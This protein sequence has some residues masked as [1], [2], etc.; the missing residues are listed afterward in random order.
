VKPISIPPSAFQMRQVD[1][2]K[3]VEAWTQEQMAQLSAQ[4]MK[5]IREL[6]ELAENRLQETFT[7]SAGM[8]AQLRQNTVLKERIKLLNAGIVALA[9]ALWEACDF[10]DS[11]VNNHIES[12][13]K[14]VKQKE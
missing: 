11:L 14:A 3:I 7:F 8:N 10:D 6:E 9:G 4:Y 2:G 13:A 1:T 5:R 12:L